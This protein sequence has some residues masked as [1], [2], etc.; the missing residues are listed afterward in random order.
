[1]NRILTICFLGL[2]GLPAGLPGLAQEIQQPV[3][4]ALTE[5]NG[6]SDNRVT[7]FYQDSRSFMWIGTENGLDRYDGSAFR[8][9]RSRRHGPDELAGNSVTAL[10]EDRQGRLWIATTEGLSVYD[11]AADSIHSWQVREGNP[12]INHFT[13]LAIDPSG[14]VW[15]GSFGGLLSFNPA[16]S[17]FRIFQNTG[18]VEGTH[19]TRSNLINSL[20]ID[21]QQRF[22]VGTFNGIWRFYPDQ[23]RF[24]QWIGDREVASGEAF[25]NRILEDH[26]GRLWVAFYNNGLLQ[27]DPASRTLVN[28]FGASNRVPFIGAVA[29]WHP[30]SVHYYL[31]AGTVQFNPSS[32]QAGPF[33][34]PP[35]LAGDAF[36]VNTVFA[37]RD[38][39][40][41]WG[42]DQGIRIID[43]AKQFFHRVDLA[44]VDI[45]HQGISLLADRTGYYLGGAGNW[46]LLKLDP[47]FHVLRRLPARPASSS[48]DKPSL[49][50]LV[51]EDA[52]HIWCCTDEGVWLLDERAQTF[53]RYHMPA[54]NP[55]APAYDFITNLF[56]DSKG[57]HWVFPWRGGIWQLDPRTG[58]L[59]Q[60]WKG[61]L[62]QN[63]ETKPLLIVHAAED[64]NGNCWFADL[65]E[66]LIA[67]DRASGRFYKP[68][69]T[70]LG[71]RFSLPNLVYARPWIWGVTTGRIFRY[72]P[73]DRTLDQWD[74][75]DEFS[76]TVYDF[77]SDT[78]RHLWITTR[79]GLLSF[80][81]R[82]HAFRRFT[83]G[84]GLPE[85]YLTE[86]I[87]SLPDGRILYTSHRYVDWFDPQAL[88]RPAPSPPVR[89]TAVY[90][91]NRLLHADPGPGG[92][93]RLD[94]SYTHNNFTFNWALL[95]YSNPLQNQYYYK[96]EGIDTGW[97]Y[98]GNR[99]EALYAGL[100]PG[101]YVFR[102]NGVPND[103][104]MS[105]PGDTLVIVIHPPFW[106]TYWFILACVL[107][108][109]TALAVTVRYVSRRNLKERLLRLEKE[110]AL[111]RER[112]RIS[113]DMHDELGSGLTKI[114][115]L[116]EVTKKQL[117]EPDRA[118][119]QL[120]QISASSREL[121]DNLQN[122]IWVLNP[123][124]DSLESLA[125]Y[126]REYALKFFEPFG[127]EL[128]FHYQ[129]PLSA[130]LSEEIRH[131]LFLVIKES[132][133]NI[134]RHAWCNRVTVT[135]AH[136]S[137]RLSLEIR[138]DG[139][140]FDPGQVRPFGNGLANMRHRI[141]QLGGSFSLQSEPGRGCCTRIEVPC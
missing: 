140:G 66:G 5:E 54:T 44:P 58:G 8:V 80:D 123:R 84:D 34:Q 112:N 62:Q 11:G 21:R 27:F 119:H 93:K 104:A 30:D 128:A 72:N 12:E 79:K 109:G 4:Y 50:N 87:W 132:F 115:I 121:V 3:V 101:R 35:T 65:D 77:C 110:Q 48:P 117:H 134:A 51:R 53:R 139:R 36:R 99:G 81:E 126:V 90:S 9:F 38:N 88:S 116:S 86:P 43:P 100:L 28:R 55:A 19:R 68:L 113:R 85:N 120:E 106:K 103:G 14:T 32:C 46:F 71:P 138:D 2:C 74:I 56:V 47:A 76:S 129:E 57:V 130:R 61:F 133:N 78:A 26:A 98:A 137:G 96:L 82:T 70:K 122:I 105:G 69:E 41:W 40:L 42:T 1:M 131:H 97:K 39:L 125:A 141:G 60:V 75:P 114:A 20:C 94:L 111:E 10:A 24:E 17:Q 37:G 7:C 22:W 95:H 92:E 6:L 89:L 13:T 102:M 52:S 124:N 31:N 108:L 91:Q 33:Y 49:L 107:V 29:E 67:F 135:L 64:E 83:T 15:I 118:R 73:A 23:A 63:N 45:T 18:L 25:V 59:R 16:T 136:G 127:T